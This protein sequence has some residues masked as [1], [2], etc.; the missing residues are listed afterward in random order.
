MIK[1]YKTLI[2]SL[3][4]FLA[5][6]LHAQTC[7]NTGAGENGAYSAT[8]NTT[9]AGG[10]YNFTTFNID[11]GVLVTIT[12]TVPLVVHTTGAVTINGT[13][14]ATGGNGNNGLT[15]TSGGIGGIGVAGGANGGAGSFSSASGPLPGIAGSGLGA[16]NNQGDGWSGG[17]GA[18]Y[19][20]VGLSSGNSAGGFGGPIYGNANISNLDAGSGGGGGSGGYDCGAGGGGAGGG[21]IVFNSGAS[22]TLG[23]GGSIQ[24]NGGNGGSDDNGNCGGGG[25]GTG[26]SIWLA[27]PNV[28]NNG[29][30]QAIGGIGGSSN[31]PNSPYFGTGSNGSDGRIRLDVNGS[32]GGIG[33]VQ[34]SSGSSYTVSTFSAIS[35]ATNTCAGSNTGIASVTVNGGLA[36]Y[37]Y[38]WSASSTTTSVQNSLSAGNYTCVITDAAMCIT[39]STVSINSN[40]SLTLTVN[41]GAICSGNS[42]TINPSGA[43]TYTFS[44]GSSIVTPITNSTYTITGTDAF[45]C[46]SSTEVVSSVTV[47]ATPTISVNSGSICSGNSFTIIPSGATTYSYSGGSAVVSPT[48]STNFTITGTSAFNCSATAV[49]S[50]SVSACVGVEELTMDN[51][52][53]IYPNP[54]STVINIDFL[55]FNNETYTIEITN[56]I[57]QILLRDNMT[58]HNLSLNTSDLKE[59]L[60]FINVIKNN[61]VITTKK[62][63]KN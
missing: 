12:G 37:T 61:N 57:G 15:Y 20:N 45:G 47:N 27:S 34:P 13:L 21:L 17:G 10:S 38:S 55:I 40:P 35:S 54:I 19:A 43:S 24:S 16:L 63:I 22:I 29:L 23:A 49:S 5:T 46:I 3:V 2:T 52:V 53:S 42:F 11:A 18:G 14:S 26:G 30:I 33:I 7:F 8:T 62:I 59:G 1:I 6:G 60:Y 32:I 56:T 41:S 28:I 31:I 44:S 50:V 36:P 4:L 39:S 51:I 25:G 48:T 9:L 58:T